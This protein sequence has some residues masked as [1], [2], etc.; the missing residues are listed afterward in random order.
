MNPHT[1]YT[2]RGISLR[3]IP[4]SETS[5]IRAAITNDPTARRNIWPHWAELS[6]AETGTWSREDFLIERGGETIGWAWLD[7][8]RW[9][10]CGSP[11]LALLPNARHRGA[12]II[13]GYL[14]AWHAFEF[15]GCH[16]IKSSAWGYNDESI[17][18]Q[19]R[20]LTSEG[21]RR[22]HGY[23]GPDGYADLLLFGL[24]RSEWDAMLDTRAA[25][26]RNAT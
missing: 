7:Y 16:K 23:S 11:G 3:T 21:V 17:R 6:S 18:M 1:P 26:D 14:L 20:F 25:I 8:D 2:C 4:A 5:A 24:L 12:G 9:S 15:V 10:R 22:D 19:Q 13:A